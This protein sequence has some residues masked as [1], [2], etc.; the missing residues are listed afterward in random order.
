[1]AG[2]YRLG[3][4]LGR[5]AMGTVW[6]AQDEL[7]GRLVAVKEV[8]LPPGIPDAAADL[9]RERSL[10]EARA[11]AALSHPNVVTLHDV[12]REDGVP[13]VVMELVA[14]HSLAELLRGGPVPAQWAVAI[15]MAVAAALQAAHAAGITHRDV[16]PGNVLV[17]H[18]GRIKLTDFGI[19]RNLADQRMTATGIILGSPAY[20]AP[21]VASGGQVSPAIDLWG[22]GATLFAAVEGRPPYDAGDPVATVSAVVLGEVPRPSCSGPLAEVICG[23]MVK[24]PARRMPL[25][26]VRRLLGTLPGTG[27]APSPIPT[28]SPDAAAQAVR[29]P[30]PKPAM[31][32]AA[33][34]GPLPFAVP[35]GRTGPAGENGPAGAE[36]R[37]APGRGVVRAAVR[38]ALAVLL[39]LSAA[40]A[41]FSAAR[42]ASGASALPDLGPGALPRTATAAN[43]PAL[44]AQ[45]L[46]VSAV[47]SEPAQVTV[48]I[49]AGWPEFREQGVLGGRSRMI[50]RFVSPDGTELISVERATGW[51]AEEYLDTYRRVLAEAV[52]DLAAGPSRELAD[53]A[54]D[55]T[56]RSREG[57]GAQGEV[58]RTTYLRLVPAGPDLWVLRVTV[59]TG[60]EA[61]G[62]SELFE[63]VVASFAPGS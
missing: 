45:Q 28:G 53:G 39:F 59:P 23:L 17:A 20:L 2:R 12:A 16:K 5:G 11:I 36:I 41:G 54:L 61:T 27:Q 49:P 60:R 58:R 48:G 7:L 10:R 8:L 40:G 50:V 47:D 35:A 57:T 42:V 38:W 25:S 55:A 3:A 4:V 44:V 34:P 21:E 24:D 33:D 62:R 18:D 15:G 63:P 52:G 22:L 46:Q 13:F 43:G 1:V 14:S 31:Q 9:L 29:P 26:Q 37:V 19:A 30:P 32:L 6:S 56:F 51:R